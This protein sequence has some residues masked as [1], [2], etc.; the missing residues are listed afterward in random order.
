MKR[1]VELRICL[2][3]VLTCYI[4]FGMFALTAC[5][6]LPFNAEWYC[7]ADDWVSEDFMRNNKINAYYPNEN[8][9]EGESDPN[10]KYLQFK[11][12]PS[13]RTFVI[14][15]REKFKEIFTNYPNEV[16][17][18][19]RV[20]ILYIFGNI[21]PREYYL[22]DIILDGEVLKVYYGMEKSNVSDAMM[23]CPRC[24]MLI[25]DKTEFKEVV[26]EEVS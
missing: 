5:G 1:F 8:Y 15:E 9:I 7:K 2:T 11:D 23:P 16:D 20:V 22:D 3:I 14:T 25:T 17:F 26:F 21:Y 19:S 6:K 24:F 12:M 10:E 4:I 13:F 18:S